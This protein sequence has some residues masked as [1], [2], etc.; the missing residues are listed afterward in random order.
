MSLRIS[1]TFLIDITHGDRS[2]MNVDHLALAVDEVD[3]DELATN[4][5]DIE[6]GPANLF[7]ARG[8]GRGI[9]LRDPDGNR[10]EVRTY[11]QHGEN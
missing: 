8:N 10:L 2:G 6:M 3:L 11:P 5:D 1:P 9:Y 4:L 7:G